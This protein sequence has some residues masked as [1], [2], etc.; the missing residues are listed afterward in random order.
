MDISNR[1]TALFCDPF[2]LTGP[3]DVQTPCS[4]QS[5]TVSSSNVHLGWSQNGPVHKLVH[6]QVLGSLLASST[7][8]VFVVESSVPVL[9]PAPPM[10]CST[11][12]PLL[13][14]H[15]PQS[16]SEVHPKLQ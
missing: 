16:D 14:A 12:H 11:T 10:V 3:P 4:P 15:S 1:K 5:V 8:Y 9:H 6:W 7:V 2:I 13:G